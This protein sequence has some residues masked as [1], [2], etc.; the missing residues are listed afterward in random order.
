MRGVVELC[1]RLQAV[2]VLAFLGTLTAG[3]S[4]SDGPPRLYTVAEETASIRANM[5][6]INLAQF[7]LMDEATRMKYRNDWIAGRMYA[8]D[9]QYTTFEGEL[10]KERQAVGFGAAAAALALNTAAG[11]TTPVVTK[12]VLTGVSSVVTGTRAAYDSDVLLAHSIQWIQNQM[13][14]QRTGIAGRIFLGMK[15]S[16][17]DYT[18]A[19]ALYD[20]EDYYRAGT[21]T[22]G[23]LATSATIGLAAAD[24]DQMLKQDTVQFAFVPSAVGNALKA[25]LNKPPAGVTVATQKKRL[26]ALMPT[27][28]DKEARFYLMVG[29]K[30]PAEAEDLLNAARIKDYCP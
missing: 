17:A 23:L 11:L 22:A 18:L 20:L 10:T 3:C 21:F 16:T 12:N 1:R 7:S 6:Q 30:L 9:I 4:V 24:V 19:Q 29:G 26:L 27:S 5:P 8:I 14:T 25:C 13:R 28:S 2:G 15:A